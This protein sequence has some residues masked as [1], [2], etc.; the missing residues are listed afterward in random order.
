MSHPRQYK[1]GGFAKNLALAPIISQRHH[2]GTDQNVQLGEDGGDA[3]NAQDAHQLQYPEALRG[4]K[5]GSLKDGEK[6]DES[7]KHIKTI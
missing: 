7:E 5:L 6:W 3:S 1:L 2:D 4:A